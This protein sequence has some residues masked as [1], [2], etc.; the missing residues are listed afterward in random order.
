MKKK[1]LFIGIDVSKSTFDAAII[2]K[3]SLQ[4]VHH[5]QFSNTKT[6]FKQMTKWIISIFP[7]YEHYSWVF[8]ME[9]TGV[10]SYHLCCFFEENNLDYCHESA[11]KINRSLGIIKREKSDKAD[12]RDIAKYLYQHIEEL[13]FFKL[14]SQSLQ[15]LKALISFRRRL[16]KQKVA[17]QASSKEISA[18]SDKETSRFIKTESNKLIKSYVQKIKKTEDEI[19][20]LMNEDPAL[21][22]AYKLTTSVVG[23]SPVIASYV[24]ART[25]CFSN[26]ESPRNF[27]SYCG[28]APFERSSGTSIKK[29]V[30]INK[31]ADKELK[32]LLTNGAYAAIRYD[33]QIRHYFQRKLKEGKNEFSVINAIR[34]KLIHRVF[35][36]VNRGTPYVK[37]SF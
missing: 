10:Y 11:L 27:A 25:N 1:E 3:G 5:K 36:T 4:T 32:S 17:L 8:C 33:G 26:F 31:M 29:V 15:K 9:Q 2:P 16:L 24:I 21:S 7:E 19:L 20:K 37:M 35:A 28:A 13:S 30:R 18:F 23:I 22:E 6:G 12:S 14:P 34:N